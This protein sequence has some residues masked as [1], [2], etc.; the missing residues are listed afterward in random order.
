VSTGSFVDTLNQTLNKLLEHP[1]RVET[2]FVIDT[3]G[4][5]TDIF[6]TLIC[7][8]S[9]SKESS[10]QSTPGSSNFSA[11][12]VACVVD[13]Y[14]SMDV[15]KFRDSYE[16]IACAKRLNKTPIPTV[17]DVPHTTTTLGII[18]ARDAEVPI[19]TLA[20]ELDSLN[21]KHPNREW[22]DMV[23]ILSKGVINYAVQFPGENVSGDFLP[24]AQ[25]ASDRYLPPIY[26][27]ALVRPTGKFTFNKMCSYLMA[28]LML[29]SPG[30]KKIELKEILGDTPVEGMA[31]HS[32][33][34][35]L[36]GSLKPVPRQFHNDRYI[37]PRPFR[38]EDQRG[39]LLS[40]MQF[41]PWQD[42][43]VILLKGKLPLEGLLIFLGKK[44]LHHSHII[45]LSGKQL[46]YV[47][48]ITHADF[49]QLLNRI[50][51]QTNMVVKPDQTKL[52]IQKMAEEGS[53]SPFMARL[54]L[55]NL[56]LRDAVFPDHSKRE[57]FDKPYHLLMETLLNTRSASKEVTQLLDEHFN[58]LSKGEIGQLRGS[59]IHIDESIDKELRK[60]FETFLNT[61]VRVLKN[62]MQRVTTV[63]Q[64][65][66]GFL[67]KKQG[68]FEN[69]LK[70]LEKSDPYLAAYLRETRK[71]SER[72]IQSRNAI[73]HEE[74][75]LPNI[76]YME[77]S[78][79]IFA[80]EPKVADQRVSDFVKLIMD[81][82]CCFVE[83]VTVHCLQARMPKGISVME[84]P[85]SQRNQDVPH[86]FQLTLADGGM[87]IWTITY[88]QRS[89]EET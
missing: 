13:V 34:Y 75:V 76:K 52:V 72:L 56:R 38:I 89:F 41:L 62:G 66:I 81:R 9:Q 7:T 65:N 82:L 79:S 14:E 88:H 67:F 20:E 6:N 58:K 28:H 51:K 25:G 24:P 64:A 16:K 44:A 74:W 33:Q 86:R 83:E 40:T 15:E 47:L 80:E 26:V 35:K 46:S 19:E 5:K 73:E 32:Y 11:D 43:G 55:G 30:S 22:T 4:Q 77:L 78:G 36:S 8:V 68:A 39:N 70:A 60:Y 63:L 2:G 61:G 50:S 84:I 69:G 17:P 87:P 1:F 57:K 3:E 29:F 71:W 45:N 53:S 12:N 85:V 37:P 49:M 23:A 21:R 27:I 18:F 48:P 31:L 42:G 10:I 59:T 54:Y